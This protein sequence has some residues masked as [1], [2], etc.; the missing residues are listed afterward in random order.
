MKDLIITRKR[1]KIEL[2]TILV[3]VV[4]A[5][6]LNAYAIIEYD[7][8]WSQLIT[9]MFYVLTFAVVLYAVWTAI[10][11]FVYLLKKVFTYKKK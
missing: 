2:I 1:Q 8:Q 9:S 7:G 6:A 5:I 10:R 4:I 11:L 3:C